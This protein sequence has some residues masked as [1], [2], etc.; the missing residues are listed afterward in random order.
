MFKDKKARELIENIIYETGCGIEAGSIIKSNSLLKRIDILEI[1]LNNLEQQNS[2]LKDRLQKVIDCL[3]L[4]EEKYV[5]T[6]D[7]FIS[8]LNGFEFGIEEDVIKTRF[9]KPKK[10]TGKWV[11]GSL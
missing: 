2:D 3:G 8:K 4:E 6:E 5:V 10:K 7:K 9:I 1:R 11:A